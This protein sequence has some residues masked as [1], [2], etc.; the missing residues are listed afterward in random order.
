MTEEELSHRRGRRP[1]CGVVMVKEKRSCKHKCRRITKW[2][3]NKEEGFI[4]FITNDLETPAD[5]LCEVYRRRWQ[6]ETLFK[7][8]KQNFPLKYFLGDNQ[9]AIQIQIWV[10][11]IAWLLMQ[12]IKSKTTR[13][14]SLSNLMVAVRILLTSYIGLYDFLDNLEAQWMKIIRARQQEQTQGMLLSLFE[15]GPVF[16]N[17][18]TLAYLSAVSEGD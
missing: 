4:T 13:M 8:L 17:Q 2:K 6:I 18:K 3:D 10:C 5:I 7:R 9:N 16:E 11:L 15:R 12:V 1:K 14:W